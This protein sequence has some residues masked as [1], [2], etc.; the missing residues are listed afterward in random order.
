MDLPGGFFPRG[1][2][3]ALWDGKGIEK[4]VIIKFGGREFPELNVNLY[5]KCREYR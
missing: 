3:F 5:F 2:L 1:G 4:T